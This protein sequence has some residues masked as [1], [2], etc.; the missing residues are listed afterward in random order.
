MCNYM[1]LKNEHN[2]SASRAFRAV[3]LKGIKQLGSQSQSRG[4]PDL[5]ERQHFSPTENRLVGR[6]RRR[7]EGVPYSSGS[8]RR[9]RVVRGEEWQI[10]RGS[11]EE[12]CRRVFAQGPVSPRG[13][14]Q[15]G[16][17]TRAVAEP[18]WGEERS[19]AGWTSLGSS[20]VSSTRQHL[21][22]HQPLPHFPRALR[23]QKKRKTTSLTRFHYGFAFSLFQTLSSSPLIR[24]REKKKE[25]GNKSWFF[26]SLPHT[27]GEIHYCMPLAVCPHP[28]AKISDVVWLHYLKGLWPKALGKAHCSREVTQ[29]T[30]KSKKLCLHIT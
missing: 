23:G 3:V 25:E 27:L 13:L 10:A 29:V 18:G 7:E 30:D 24:C 4:W 26:P 9:R 11:R 21:Q 22:R 2:R 28:K 17:S 15:G 12:S 20:R 19:S 16:C 6:K 1:Q 8:V 5:R 14:W